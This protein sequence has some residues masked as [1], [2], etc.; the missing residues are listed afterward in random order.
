MS[1]CERQFGLEQIPLS[2]QHVQIVGQSPFVAESGESQRR[3]ERLHLLRLSLPLLAGRAHRN[4]RVFDFSKRQQDRLLVLSD[5]L[6]SLCLIRLLL[7][8]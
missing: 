7:K 4:E 6:A 2:D 3:S 1:S 8:S 5:R